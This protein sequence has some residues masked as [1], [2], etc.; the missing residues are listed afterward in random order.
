VLESGKICNLG[1]GNPFEVKEMLP[2]GLL[3]NGS[4]GVG[5]NLFI[6]INKTIK[7]KGFNQCN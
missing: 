2:K 5:S 7:R 3:S 1:K 6:L 4:Q